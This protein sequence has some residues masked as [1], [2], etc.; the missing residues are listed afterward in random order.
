MPGDSHPHLHLWNAPV[1]NGEDPRPETPLTLSSGEAERAEQLACQETW[2]SFPSRK[3][4]E[5]EPYSRAWFE[6]IEHRRYKQQGYWLTRRMEFRRRTGDK[7]LCLGHGLGTDWVQYARHGAQVIVLHP[8]AEQLALVRSNFEARQLS[9]QWVQGLFTALPQRN[10][11][12]DVVCLSGLHG[13]LEELPAVTAEIYRVL[14]PGGKIIGIL[15]A[16]YNARR[17][18]ELC[19]PW[20]GWFHRA[21]PPATDEPR[22]SATQLYRHF[23]E[24]SEHRLYKRHLRR[25]DLPHLWRWLP[26]PVSERLMGKYLLLKAF[27]PL[28]SALTS[29]A[30]A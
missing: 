21:L 10:N 7:I 1:A 15:P 11:S 8:A 23:N 12:M 22:Y 16:W 2:R 17:W 6:W 29:A 24:F 27:K 18:Q 30:A 20:L 28:S 26:L 19:L 5:L 25:A 14:R 3:R 9:A 4:T 13:P